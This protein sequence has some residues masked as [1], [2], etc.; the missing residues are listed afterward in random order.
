MCSSDLAP[1][2]V[3]T[4]ALIE[5]GSAINVVPDTARL[6]VGVRLLPGVDPEEVESRVQAH[7]ATLLGENL[8]MTRD[9]LSPPMPE[10]PNMQL[11]SYLQDI[12]VAL[13]PHGAPFG[14]DGGML[15]EKMGVKSLLWGPGS[16]QN[17]HQPDEWIELR[18]LAQME[19]DLPRLLG[20]LVV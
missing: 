8:W 10:H 2:L 14:T 9:A 19:C 15:F 7:L 18:D 4:V 12:G 16:I 3:L 6:G 13:A 11:R 5:G 1:F 17:A 20:R